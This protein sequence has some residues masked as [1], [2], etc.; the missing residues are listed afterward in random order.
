[1]I[2]NCRGGKVCS[3]GMKYCAAYS[4]PF[5]ETLYKTTRSAPTF[6]Y[7]SSSFYFPN[8]N[9]YVPD[10]RSHSASLSL[11]LSLPPNGLFINKTFPHL[12]HLLRGALTHL[13]NSSW[14][15]SSSWRQKQMPSVSNNKKESHLGMG[16]VDP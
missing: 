3:S 5:T 10:L 12:D 14:N 13:L 16:V 11:S 2:R 1:M 7:F 15:A 4:L 8:L 9:I 6:T